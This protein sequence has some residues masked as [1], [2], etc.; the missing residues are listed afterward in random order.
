MFRKRAHNLVKGSILAGLDIGSTKTVCFIAQVVDDDS[1]MEI[2]GVG[3]QASEGVSAGVVTD[4][5]L[6]EASIRKAIHAAENMA[7]SSIK[8]YPLQ[9]VIIGVNARHV[10]TKLTAVDIDVD[11][12]RVGESDIKSGILKSQAKNL[13]E[14]HEW[15]HT[16]PVGFKLDG[17]SGLTDPRGMFGSHL[18]LELACI[19][20][21]QSAIK[22]KMLCLEKSHLEVT[23]A[24]VGAYASGLSCLAK[25]EM[26]LGCVVIDMGGGSTQIA[27]FYLGN[28]LYTWA[29]PVGGNHVTRDIA[30]GLNTSIEEAERVKT[31]HGS[32]LASDAGRI[33][34]IS[35]PLLGEEGGGVHQVEKS[36]LVG[37][38]RPRL[39]ETFEMLRAHIEDSGLKDVLGRNVVLTGG[40]S[41]MP[42]VRELAQ[43]VLDKKVRIGRPISI[44]GLPEA[45]NGPGFS[46][47]SGL[48][49]YMRDRYDEQ[50]AQIISKSSPETLGQKIKYWIQENW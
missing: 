30:R 31:L 5:S 38:I 36:A 29:I 20:A 17:Q 24:C 8:G 35:V 49:T 9:E 48:L 45:A 16:I 12:E 42:G 47:A 39:E 3:H 44:S 15:L 13:P 43:D 37:I 1:T 46:T 41:Q 2:V 33:D 7:A 18:T 21:E 50:P 11:G 19:S 23:T 14:D 4:I 25:D 28:L 22:N 26:D 34:T 32:S 27:V 10:Q 6:A 40:A